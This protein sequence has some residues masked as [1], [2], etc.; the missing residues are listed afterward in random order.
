MRGR[1]TIIGMGISGMWGSFLRRGGS[2]AGTKETPPESHFVDIWH[3]RYANPPRRE[4]DQHVPY[5]VA[6]CSCEWISDAHDESDPQ[7]EER[8]REAARA[9]SP[10]V[11]ETVTYPLD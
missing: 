4:R 6:S 11:A 3:V 7:A 8:A 10:H 1:A 5:F 2:T 9:H